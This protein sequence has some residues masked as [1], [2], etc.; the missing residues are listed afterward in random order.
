MSQDE[1]NFIVGHELGHALFEHYALPTHGILD[2]GNI[3]AEKAMRLMSWSRRAEVS[4]DRAGLYICK[5]AGRYQFIFKT[6]L[7]CC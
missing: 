6:V 5:S 4:A 3:D 1:L 2:E 7:R